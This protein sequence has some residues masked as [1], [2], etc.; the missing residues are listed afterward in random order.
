MP[1]AVFWDLDG[2][3]I[4]SDPYWV[5]AER[6]LLERCG[7]AW[8]DALAEAMQG[9]ALPMIIRL[10][11]ERGVDLPD[12]VIVS[13]LTDQVMCMER[14]RLPWIEG[15]CELLAE[16][17]EACVPSVLVTGSPRP[18]VDNV[19]AHAPA[20]S[21]VGAIS[22]DDDVPHK[23]DPAPY[24]A[25]ARI[26]VTAGSE[27]RMRDSG[28]HGEGVSTGNASIPSRDLMRRCVIFEDSLPGLAAARASGGY[29]IAV[30]GHARVPVAGCGRYDRMIRDYRGLRPSDLIVGHP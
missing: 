20:G 1:A 13:T 17:A 18:I 5:R 10:L 15:A 21:F 25:A 29:V 30:T 19:L 27:H 7:G 9:A 16:L 12:E 8:D 26:A 11:R 24:L 4:D 23:P 6:A 3:L 28:R 2:T 22:G 14:E